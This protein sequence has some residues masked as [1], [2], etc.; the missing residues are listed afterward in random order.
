VLGANEVETVEFSVTVQNNV[1]II[2]DINNTASITTDQT[3]R[4]ESTAVVRIFVELP[5]TGGT[6]ALISVIILTLF[7]IT[8]ATYGVYKY[9]RG[10]K[11]NLK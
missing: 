2:A 1:N 10:N 9:K 7:T 4:K 3:P 11:L 6:I 8:G 5:R